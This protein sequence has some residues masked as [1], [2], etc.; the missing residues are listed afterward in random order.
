M[1]FELEWQG[2]ENAIFLNSPSIDSQFSAGKVVNELWLRVFR[3]DES[4]VV[5]ILG[6]FGWVIIVCGL[7]DLALDTYLI[8]NKNTNTNT[9]TIDLIQ[10]IE[11]KIFNNFKTKHDM[12]V[13]VSC[14]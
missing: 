7:G 2:S 1:I 3:D 8:S 6:V 14:L 12:D 4:E 10:Q 13:Q 9:N 5:S 11:Y